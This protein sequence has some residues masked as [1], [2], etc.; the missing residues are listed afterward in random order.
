M[1]A[2][3]LSVKARGETEAKMSGYMAF[4][5]TKSLSDKAEVPH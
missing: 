4:K 2:K 1:K 5:M 3:I